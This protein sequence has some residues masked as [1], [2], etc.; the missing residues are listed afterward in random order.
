MF[1]LSFR[2]AV[3]ISSTLFYDFSP[4]S[5]PFAGLTH[6]EWWFTTQPGP[7][8]TNSTLK[9]V[10]SPGLGS[11]SLVLGSTKAGTV[12]QFRGERLM[13]FGTP[14]VAYGPYGCGYNVILD[15]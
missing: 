6:N 4:L 7:I 2:Y 5:N 9:M 15:E 13:D 1:L 12:V 3:A 8:L 14:T 10:L 11:T